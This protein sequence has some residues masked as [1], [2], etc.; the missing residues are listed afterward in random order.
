[1]ATAEEGGVVEGG[2]GDG[3]GLAAVLSQ[4]HQSLGFVAVELAG[5]G[6]DGASQLLLGEA[7][8]GLFVEARGEGLHLNAEAQSLGGGAGGG[9]EEGTESHGSWFRG[10][11]GSVSLAPLSEL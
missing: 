6:A 10:W 8:A 2:S 7:D 3:S 1:M 4:Q 11:W 9:L 5:G